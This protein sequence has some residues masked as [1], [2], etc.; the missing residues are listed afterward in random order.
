MHRLRACPVPSILLS[1]P[2]Q[3][4]RS[5]AVGMQKE[6][7]TGLW[8]KGL[9]RA[10]KEGGADRRELRVPDSP[11]GSRGSA[12]EKPSGSILLNLSTEELA[13]QEKE[14]WDVMLENDL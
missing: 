4:A 10:W 12:S 7:G 5:R 14:A 2:G 3:A 1:Q 11:Q 6:Q 13:G 9:W 8:R